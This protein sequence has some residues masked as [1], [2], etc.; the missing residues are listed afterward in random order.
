[1]SLKL[2]AAL[3]GKKLFSSLPRFP[4]GPLTADHRLEDLNHGDLLSHTSGVQKSKVKV[5]AKLC[6]LSGL[7]GE[8]ACA[9]CSFWWLWMLLGLGLHPL[10]SAW[11]SHDLSCVSVC[12][13]SC[14]FSSED[15]SC[16]QNT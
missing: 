14:P 9:S 13:S 8:S 10:V 5:L 11:S 16:S 12:Q 1:M 3:G 15:T 6:P 7:G 2:V 4:E